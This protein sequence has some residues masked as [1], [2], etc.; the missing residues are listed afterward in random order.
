M[1]REPADPAPPGAWARVGPVRQPSRQPAAWAERRLPVP[2]VAHRPSPCAAAPAARLPHALPGGSHL[3]GRTPEARQAAAARD[4]AAR[5]RPAEGSP[6]AEAP[7]TE[8]SSDP[9]C[10]HTEPS[11]GPGRAPPGHAAPTWPS[12]RRSHR[13]CGRPG[14]M[15]QH[16]LPAM[17][18]AAE[19]PPQPNDAPLVSPPWPGRPEPPIVPVL[20]GVARYFAF[21]RAR[22]PQLGR[23]AS[24]HGIKSVNCGAGSTP[25]GADGSSRLRTPHPTRNVAMRSKMSGSRLGSSGSPRGTQMMV[26]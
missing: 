24:D 25:R 5:A 3:Q 8:Q 18:Q 17:R 16:P 7:G 9:H 15:K 4:A 10:G 20:A 21:N 12:D 6:R 22:K 26:S 13:A 1:R 2:A 11:R 19:V 14:S 23:S